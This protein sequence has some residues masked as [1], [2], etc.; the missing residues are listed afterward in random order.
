[1]KIHN[2]NGMQKSLCDILWELDDSSELY[3]FLDG[4]PK[5]LRKE[6][7]SLMQIMLLNSFD[8]TQNDEYADMMSD[9]SNK[10]GH[11]IH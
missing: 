7:E 4:L 8:N 11:T 5:R 10:E 6:A 2:L 9:I 3:V 1:M